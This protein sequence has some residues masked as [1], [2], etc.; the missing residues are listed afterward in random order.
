VFLSR[1][2]RRN[3]LVLVYALAYLAVVVWLIWRAVR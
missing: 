2:P 1:H 3:G